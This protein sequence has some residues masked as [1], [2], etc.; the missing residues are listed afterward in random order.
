MSVAQQS[1]FDTSE[2]L[3]IVQAR[4]EAVRPVL[5]ALLQVLGLRTAVDVGCGIGHFSAFLKGLGFDVVGIDGRGQNVAQAMS[6]YPG[7]DFREGNVED[8][9]L[10][11]LGSFDLVFCMGLLYHLENP[12][13]GIRRLRGITRTCLL[14]ESMCLPDEG[15]WMQL[16]E[17]PRCDNQ[18]LTDVAFYA[19]EGCLT[20]ML[21]RAGFSH[22]YRFVKL[23][24]HE[25]FRETADHR[26]RRTVLLASLKPIS[27]PELFSL[28]EPQ[29]PPDPWSK[30]KPRRA[31]IARRMTIFL[32]KP[33]HEK[34]RSFY[35][36]WI[37]V[38]PNIPLPIRLPFGAWFM[39]RNDGLGSTLTYDGFEPNERSFVARFLKQGMTVLDIGAHHGFYTLLA[40]KLVGPSG[41]V[42]AFEPSP[43]ER[44]A[45][46]LNLILN[47][48][49]NVF[50]QALALSDAA[51]QADLYVVN[52]EHTGFNS[53]R[54]PGISSP[55]IRVKV[56]VKRLDDWLRQANLDRV[57]FVKLDVEGG[58]FAVLKGGVHF[59]ERRPRPIILVE[60]EDARSGP[61]GHLASDT[62]GLLREHGFQWFAVLPGGA[63]ERMPEGADQFEG[64]FVAVPIE[65][66]ADVKE[67]T[68]N[69][70]R[71]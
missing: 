49:K 67:L 51:T 60:L 56:S 12:F 68:G 31:S 2:A 30:R 17:E 54:P 52:D 5:E 39:A 23:P 50:T 61:W 58:E 35:A 69:G 25:D 48:C 29:D 40:S 11:A 26:R 10:A 33:F 14:V 71:P 63:L 16:R 9:S 7:I 18:S 27:S 53:L 4:Q 37:R 38:F 46:H 59:L 45:L 28:T 44:K 1:V 43:R 65:R 42:F 36:R 32:R 20:K 21:F 66:L 62:A 8:G 19:S 3:R 47:R 57:D 55:T 70:S 24:D 34:S 6:R 64:N 13:L 41:K 15:L 22:V